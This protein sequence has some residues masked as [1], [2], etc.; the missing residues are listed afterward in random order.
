MSSVR[1]P[2]FLSAEAA[3]PE[4]EAGEISPLAEHTPSSG[5]SPAVGLRT[6]ALCA[7]RSSP[8]PDEDD[9]PMLLEALGEG[10]YR[11]GADWRP[12]DLPADPPAGTRLG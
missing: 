7:D 4:R 6:V 1:L 2:L 11:P 5:E 3:T 10:L 8:S 12:D 9:E